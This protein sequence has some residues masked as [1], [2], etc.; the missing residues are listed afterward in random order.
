[1]GPWLR[2]RPLVLLHQVQVVLVVFGSIVDGDILMMIQY[3][4]VLPWLLFWSVADRSEG[5]ALGGHSCSSGC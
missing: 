1:M 3:Q 4:S 2:I 5:Q